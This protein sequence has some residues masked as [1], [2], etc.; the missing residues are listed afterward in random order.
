MGLASG[1]VFWATV[2]PGRVSGDAA[3][4]VPGV[5]DFTPLFN[6]RDLTGWVPVNVAP[7]TFTVRE[8]TII[9][10]GVPTGILRTTRHYENFILELEWRHMRNGGNA[11][12]FIYSEPLTAPGVPFAKSIE[13]QIIDGDSPEG[14]WTG[15]GDMFSIHGARMKPDRPHPR[16]WERCLPSEKRAHP[17]GQWN[18][19]RVES[20]AGRL[21]LA[22]NG[23]V[24][25]GGSDCR[26]RKGYVCLESEG[27]ECHFRNLRIHEL[28]GSNP[29]PGEVAGFDRGFNSLYSGVDLAGWRTD[30]EHAGHWE[31][32]DW[33]LD[34]DGRG[35]AELRSD[36]EWG[37]CELICD[38]RMKSS[39]GTAGVLVGPVT[40]DEIRLQPGN[41]SW[42]RTTVTIQGGR[43]T[44]RHGERLAAD[45]EPLASPVASGPVTLR[46]HGA[47]VQF[48]NLFVRKA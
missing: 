26:P 11:G 28:P 6:G 1:G 25:S 42:T 13:V 38:W 21:T 32:K 7:G 18:H 30:A 9:S 46:H 45:A 19:Y 29:P 35:P 20:R 12:L 8:G 10:T 40:A 48:A 44:V 43:R 37:D 4:E 2:V 39:D 14:V 36:Q 16:G 47:P 33:I 15:H 27:S 3:E 5:E 31:P 34:S 41:T 17:A 22:V 24:V 23:K